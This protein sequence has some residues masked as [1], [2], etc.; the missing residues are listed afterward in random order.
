MDRRSILP[1]LLAGTTLTIGP[2][3]ADDADD[4]AEVARLQTRLHAE[5]PATMRVFAAEFGSGV[6]LM[7]RSPG[8]MSQQA[9]IHS[10]SAWVELKPSD[11]TGTNCPD[12]GIPVAEFSLESGMRA[13][14]KAR[15]IA[16]E[17]QAD[18]VTPN[19]IRFSF[20]DDRC[21][22]GWRIT[23]VVNDARYVYLSFGLDGTL[24]QVKRWEPDGESLLDAAN[25]RTMDAR[26]SVTLPVMRAEA[27][28]LPAEAQILAPTGDEY[29]VA[30]IAGKAY[31]C[32]VADIQFVY[33]YYSVDM[34]CEGESIHDTLVLTIADVAP[35]K[36]EHQMV[37]GLP[38]PELWMRQGLIELESDTR[39]GDTR[40]WIDA[41]DTRLIEGRF[42]GTV[43][44]ASGKRVRIADGR[45][46]LV[47]DT[48]FRVTPP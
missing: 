44:N 22:P 45:F 8:A 2:A 18:T 30:S 35:G 16:R 1:L 19:D 27:E 34:R 5:L 39:L 38:G 13:F 43:T 42:E 10:G 29:L 25:V 32:A 40:V 6:T 14:L 26:A 4:L 9:G 24:A 28:P 15:A 12:S 23:L 11:Y 36:S 7:L 47:P 46:R 31:A 3:V 33:D 20:E 17:E 37:S 48:G 41:L 21:A